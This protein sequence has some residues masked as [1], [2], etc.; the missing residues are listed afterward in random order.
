MKRASIRIT[1]ILLSGRHCHS[2]G[3]MVTALIFVTVG[4]RSLA[5]AVAAHVASALIA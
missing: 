4:S 1:R 3:L 5:G 2:L